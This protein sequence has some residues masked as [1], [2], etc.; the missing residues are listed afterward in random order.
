MVW[1][2]LSLV[3]L[4][5]CL[6]ALLGATL[7]EQIMSDRSRRQAQRQR[8][9]NAQWRAL[10]AQQTKWNEGWSGYIHLW[11]NDKIKTEEADWKS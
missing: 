10:Q 11:P 1:A 7:A 5:I 6:G 2:I 4:A 3:V 8:E 9:L